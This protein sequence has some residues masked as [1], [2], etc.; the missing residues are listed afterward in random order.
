[1]C[2]I[3]FHSPGFDVSELTNVYA[4]LQKSNGGHG[5]GYWNPDMEAPTKGVNV[6]SKEL[7]ELAA[8]AISPSV[9]HT[10]LVS[11]GSK[12]DNLCHPF[13]VSELGGVLVHNG[14]WSGWLGYNKESWSN[15]SSDTS[16]VAELISKY[17][18]GVLLSSAMSKSGV[19]M[20]VQ[21]NGEAIFVKRS[22]AFCLQY[23]DDGRWFHASE[24]V[25]G[26]GVDNGVKIGDDIAFRIDADGLPRKIDLDPVEPKR[27]REYGN[28]YTGSTHY[29]GYNVGEG[30]GVTTTNKTSIARPEIGVLKQFVADNSAD[31]EDA[32]LEDTAR[33]NIWIDELS[34]GKGGACELC[35][36]PS[37][38]EQCPLK[39]ISKKA[40]TISTALSVLEG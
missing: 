4:Q 1:M 24:Y 26:I 29:G 20:Y 37:K 10:R 14:T 11:T 36:I 15:G 28:V 32:I 12:V 21:P 38:C 33:V 7:A 22:G 31:I 19:W 30:T 13:P 16:L 6:T 3:A 18:P 23:L 8:L 39:T 9:F 40:E 35:P 27:Q 17:G 25:M 2:R 34:Q 5:N